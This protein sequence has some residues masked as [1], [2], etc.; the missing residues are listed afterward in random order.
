MTSVPS[1]RA[2]RV[3]PL[4]VAPRAGRLLRVRRDST[5]FGHTGVVSV[6]A[7]QFNPAGDTA[8]FSAV[9]STGPNDEHTKDLVRTAL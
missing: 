4:S 1:G 9:P 8:L 3:P 7:A 5:A 2:H 6:S